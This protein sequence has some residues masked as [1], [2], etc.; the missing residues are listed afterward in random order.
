MKFLNQFLSEFRQG[1]QPASRFRAYIFP[2]GKL[3]TD[4]L[5]SLPTITNDILADFANIGEAIETKTSMPVLAQWL[6]RGLLCE[7]TSLPDRGF[8]TFQR[9]IY[10][11]NEQF[12]MFTAYT[13]VSCVFTMPYAFGDNALPRFMSYWQNYVQDGTDGPESGG[14]NFRFPN[15]YYGSMLLATYDRKN[16]PT[17]IYKFV[18]LYPKTTQAVQV[19]WEQNNT[20]LKYT[21]EFAY[22]SWSI[23]SRTDPEAVALIAAGIA[24]Q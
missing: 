16:Q 5:T 4:M 23:L 1:F 17:I 9:S 21:V 15:D 3:I 6:A 20:L 18:N 10:G 19:A 8:E 2:P 24:G 11:Y 22:S 7:A 14:M 13:E 12:P